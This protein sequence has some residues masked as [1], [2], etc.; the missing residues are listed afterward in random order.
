[1]VP[2]LIIEE[3]ARRRSSE[4]QGVMGDLDAET[5]RTEQAQQ[6]ERTPRE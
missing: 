2:S 4:R 3:L 1:M 6:E 5:A